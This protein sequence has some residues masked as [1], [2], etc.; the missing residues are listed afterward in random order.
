MDRKKNTFY[1]YTKV[2]RR[3]KIKTVVGYKKTQSRIKRVRF[4][5]GGGHLLKF[6]ST[7]WR[8]EFVK[9]CP[10]GEATD[11]AAASDVDAASEAAAWY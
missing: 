8:R 2:R 9:D 1:I 10:A 7:K 6:K 5:E 3:G 11:A 4:W